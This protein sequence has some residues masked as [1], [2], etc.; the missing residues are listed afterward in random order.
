MKSFCSLLLALI[1]APSA[2]ATKVLF[3]GNSFTHGGNPYNSSR[4]TDLNGNGQGGVPGIFQKLADEGGFTDVA[5]SIEAVSGQTL[6]YHFA[7]KR[8]LIDAEWDYVVLQDHS[9]RPLTRHSSG[10]VPLFRQSVRDLA[11]LVE[12]RNPAVRVILYETWARP[13]QVPSGAYPTLR[14]MQDDLLE[15]YAAAAEDFALHGWAPVGE[16]FLR[17]LDQGVAHAP[18]SAPPGGVT[19]WGGDNYHANNHG[20][21]LSALVF[22]ARILR[23]DPRQLPRGADS[24]AV[25]LGVGATVAEQLQRIAWEAT[26]LGFLE[27]PRPGVVFPG[28]AVRFVA[29]ANDSNVNYQWSR[30][31]APIPAAS[32]RVLDIPSAQATDAGLYR[33]RATHRLGEAADSAAA[34]LTLATGAVSRTW[35]IDL[36]SASAGYPTTS[37]AADGRHWNNLSTATAGGSLASLL[38]ADGTPHPTATLQVAS[39]F[40]G[41][42]FDG[43][44]T[45]TSSEPA[46]ARRDSFFVTGTGSVG[47]QKAGVLRFSGLDPNAR[48][49]GTIFAARANV[50]T[51]FTRFT[52]GALPPAFLQAGGNSS[53]TATLSG[54]APAANGSLSLSVE[55]F[56]AAGVE[57]EYGYLNYVTVTERQ[58]TADAYAVWTSRRMLPAGASDPLD[59]PDGDGAPNLLE[60]ALGRNPLAIDGAGS[61]PVAIMDAEGRLVIDC[62]LAEEAAGSV[63]YV[64]EFSDDLVSWVSGPE[65]SL[66]KIATPTRLR[67]RDLVPMTA[68]GRRFARLRVE[69]R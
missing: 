50:G 58:P 52:W 61:C 62:L 9:L 67:V 13:D 55:P 30:N 57:Q 11:S 8:A 4:I 33:V 60:F 63:R 5:V 24:A 64:V 34:T 1:V 21:Y 12:A 27:Q 32:G 25:A 14:A 19:L 43:P 42:N 48:Y 31:G 35:L 56:D 23:A 17:A 53:A 18:G 29:R 39:S 22:Y 6:Q 40:S 59:D 10:N 2:F 54:A 47:N 51:R 7:N 26:R 38:L 46:T 49:D 16:A 28:G 41:V 36:G 15:N 20:L 3:V 37:P 66:I 65:H 44:D 45:A 68:G 69:L